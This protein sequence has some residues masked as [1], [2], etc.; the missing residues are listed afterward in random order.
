MMLA[1]PSQMRSLWTGQQF[2][3]GIRELTNAC[4]LSIL[5]VACNINEA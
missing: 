5:G 3:H 2:Y 4:L 1:I